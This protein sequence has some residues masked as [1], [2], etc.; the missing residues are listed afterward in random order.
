MVRFVLLGAAGVAALSLAAGAQTALFT[1]TGSATGDQLGKSVAGVGDVDGDGWSDFALGAPYAD[2]NGVDS[3]SVKV[4]SGRT[5]LV[6][7]TF[8]GAVAG[9]RLG[10][11]VAGAGDV[12]LDGHA[13]I[14]AG[15]PLNDQNGSNAGMAR[16]YSGA[17]GQVLFTFYGDQAGDW[18][19]ASVD[20]VGDF[21]ND[22]WPDVIVGAPYGKSAVAGN[23]GEARVFSGHD[24]S[25]LRT[26]N[27]TT[28]VTALGTTVSGAGDVDQDGWDDVIIGAPQFTNGSIND[29]GRAFVYSGKTGAQI[30][31]WTGATSGENFATCV[32]GGR[33]VNNDGWPDLVVG[34]PFADYNG[35][36]S[37]SVYVFSGK[38]GAQLYR[39]NGNNSDELGR[40]C[41]LAGDVDG[42]GWADII[43]GARLAD[44]AT[45]ADAGLARIWSGRTGQTLFALTGSIVGEFFGAA[46]ACGGDI[47]HDGLDDVVVGWPSADYAGLD[48]GRAKTWTGTPLPVTTYCTA[49]TNGLGCAATITTTGTPSATSTTAF[50]IRAAQVVNNKTGLLFYGRH[51]DALPYLGGY[52][53]VA[54]PLSRTF[55]QNSAGLATGSS[56]TGV[57][58]LN[59]NGWIQGNNDPTLGSGDTVFAQFW[60]RDVAGAGTAYTNAV[61]FT[62]M[63]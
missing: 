40:S 30:W 42:D 45:A 54:P 44:A 25:V 18:F 47:N 13:D 37:G 58:T 33:D 7:F 52:L 20:G 14:I 23:V 31:A 34:D 3:G 35:G 41:A 11:S 2:S 51:G 38:T 22:G 6:L 26:F 59:M 48:S 15:A 46:V 53:C 10:E 63:P 29:T 32:D 19:G 28:G 62:I 60:Y 55:L 1:I 49:T 8:K 17:T 16:V 9:D 24:G 27:A 61:L 12:N 56:C 4:I 57:L 36:N 50:T 39:F 43:G 21:N 5:G